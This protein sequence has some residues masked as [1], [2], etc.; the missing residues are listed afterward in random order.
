MPIALGDRHLGEADHVSGA[1]L[2]LV[3]DRNLIAKALGF[4]REPLR[5]RWVLPEVG[6]V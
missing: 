5:P 4:L 3:P 1:R 6:I 2:Q